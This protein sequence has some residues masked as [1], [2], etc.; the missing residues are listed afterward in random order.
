MAD[1]VLSS[2]LAGHSYVVPGRYYVGR[3]AQ[4]AKFARRWS[5][6]TF[7]GSQ[8]RRRTGVLFYLCG[9][10]FPYRRALLFL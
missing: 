6:C 2:G 3:S 10:G 8:V 9:C 4:D 1:D 7:S 5:S